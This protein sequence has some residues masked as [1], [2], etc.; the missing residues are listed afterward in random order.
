MKNWQSQIFQKKSNFGE[1][2]EKFL[3]NRVFGFCRKFNPLMC[4]FDNKNSV[5][6][7]F[8][9]LCEICMPVKNLIFQLWPKI[10]L[11]NHPEGLFDHQYP[12]NQLTDVLDFL[13][14]DYPFWLGVASCASNL[15]RLQDSL[16]INIS[17]KN[18]F[19]A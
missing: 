3:Q 11:I 8:L 4:L 19:I 13:H 9:W 10:L 2:A 18:Q 14:K 1:K 7:C 5:Q 12:W 17:A 15:I 16:I 6:L